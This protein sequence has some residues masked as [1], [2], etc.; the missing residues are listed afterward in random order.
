M[1]D[2]LVEHHLERKRAKMKEHD[3]ATIKTPG[4]FDRERTGIM[5]VGPIYRAMGPLKFSD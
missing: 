3:V 4:G 5:D 1:A 2:I